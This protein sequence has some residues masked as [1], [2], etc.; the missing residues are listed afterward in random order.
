MRNAM[1]ESP[2]CAKEKFVYRCE[3]LF[4][5]SDL[6]NTAMPR[7]NMPHKYPEWEKKNTNGKIP[8]CHHIKLMAVASLCFFVFGKHV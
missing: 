7:K 3:I 4:Y 5:P 6:L 8:Y 2:V 1:T